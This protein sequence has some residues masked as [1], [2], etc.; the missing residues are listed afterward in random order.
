VPVYRLARLDRD[1]YLSRNRGYPGAAAG[2]AAAPPHLPGEGWTATS[3]R[4]GDPTGIRAT[5]TTRR[6][7][8][9]GERLTLTRMRWAHPAMRMVWGCR[10]GAGVERGLRIGPNMPVRYRARWS[11]RDHSQS[12][13]RWRP[14]RWAAC[15][16]MIRKLTVRSGSAEWRP[17]PPACTRSQR[18]PAS[19]P[20]CR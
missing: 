14:T 12:A 17:S 4:G 6:W 15:A 19:R 3:P 18:C 9:R 8:P 7:Q 5:A 11:G 13:P 2:W 16:T 1:G 20:G 10:G